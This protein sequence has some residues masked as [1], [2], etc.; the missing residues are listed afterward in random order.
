MQLAH[1][2]RRQSLARPCVACR[3]CKISNS[4][5][6]VRG[7]RSRLQLMTCSFPY[8]SRKVQKWFKSSV[9][10][11]VRFLLL[12][13]PA[14]RA[15]TTIGLAFCAGLDI[16]SIL[17]SGASNSR[18][19]ALLHRSA[20]FVTYVGQSMLMTDELVAETPCALERA[21]LWRFQRC[22]TAR[23]SCVPSSLHTCRYSTSGHCWLPR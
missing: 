17:R 23:N 2:L 18:H 11:L 22:R 3:P 16:R 1:I 21:E 6:V 12:G 10:Y 7:F 14:T 5:S 13:T 20:T 4:N 9:T 8:V 15:G 19:L